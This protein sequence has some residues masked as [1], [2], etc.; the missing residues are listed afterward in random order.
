MNYQ[1]R[2]FICA[3]SGLYFLV[4]LKDP[5]TIPIVKIE[6]PVENNQIEV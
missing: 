2:P 4:R 6:I 1:I 3:S 5:G